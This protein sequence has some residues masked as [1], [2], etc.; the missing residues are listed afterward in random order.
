VPE[1][2]SREI[3]EL[4]DRCLAT[5]AAARPTAQELVNVL[6]THVALHMDELLQMPRL[7]S[8]DNDFERDGKLT[9][10]ARQLEEQQ[11]GMSSGA[12]N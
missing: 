6:T 5:D 7:T 3:A 9:T 11:L 8:A 10:E 1:E 4:I 12:D 2:C